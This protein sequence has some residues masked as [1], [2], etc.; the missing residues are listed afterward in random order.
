MF[1]RKNLASMRS[2]K[3]CRPSRHLA[4]SSSLLALLIATQAYSASASV[5]PATVSHECSAS[6]STTKPVQFLRSTV[7][8]VMELKDADGQLQESAYLYLDCRGKFATSSPFGI[9]GTDCIGVRMSGLDRSTLS[10]AWIDPIHPQSVSVASSPGD[11]PVVLRWGSRSTFRVFEN[12]RVEWTLTSVLTERTHSGV[13][14][15]S[16]Q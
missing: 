8:L 6:W 11:V 1:L 12:D 2:S 13:V 4:E 5:F 14:E 10:T 9:V 3:R 15:C 16:A 7:N